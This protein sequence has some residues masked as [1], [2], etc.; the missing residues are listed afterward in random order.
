MPITFIPFD[1]W[2]P[3]GG[4]FGEGW[5]TT[6][7]IYP[8]FGDNR[9]WPRFTPATGSVVD[10]YMT[11]AYAHQWAAGMGGA[12]YTPDALTLFCGS[13]SKLYSVDPST[14]NFTNLSRGAAYNAHPGGWRFC[15]V[16]NDIWAANWLDVL[17]RRT[18]NTG[19]FADGAVST[20]TPKAR[21]LTTVREHLVVANL[22]NAGRYQD[23]TAWSDANDATNFD[24]AATGS[25]STSIAG[26]KRLVSIPGQ[27]TGL[28][29]GQ[30]LLAFKRRGI[31]YGEYV[32]A[33]QIFNF[34]VLSTSAGTAAPSSIISSR[35]GVFFFG[36]DG[37][38]RISG[39]SEPQKVSP[40]GVD[41]YL[42]NGTL[43]GMNSVYTTGSREDT[44]LYAFQMCDRPLIG[45]AFGAWS[46]P[47]NSLLLLYNPVT[48]K[49]GTASVG[50]VSSGGG[51][52][53]GSVGAV[54]SLPFALTGY[55]SVAGLLFDGVHTA[56]APLSR[57]GVVWGPSLSLNFRPVNVDSQARQKRGNQFGQ[58]M[59]HGV[60]PVFSKTTTSGTA[61]T[62]SVTAEALLDP[63]GAPI[64]PE[65]RVSTDRNAISGYYPFTLSGRFFRISIQCAAEDFANFEGV[66]VH[67]EELGPE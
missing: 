62:E 42:F 41:Q 64:T 28:V 1:G 63:H 50:Y 45:W 8:A 14:G 57:S 43:N 4:Y 9:P 48:D 19:S 18:D 38:Y 37:I 7:N 58:S 5:N 59:L 23:E 33:P 11:G 39:L 2:T 6:L 12:T 49:W 13:D 17:Q 31:F 27:I 60:L 46:D 3:S 44:Q 52:A 40:P 54:F 56:Y 53:A 20:F 47:A 15:S 32:G 34:D 16:G 26:A 10:P 25:T 36:Q 35:Y 66:F 65:T 29:G 24:P 61:L 55:D 30:Y 67:F 51:L 21:F 22:S